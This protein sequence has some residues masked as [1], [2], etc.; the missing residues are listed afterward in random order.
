[1]D[2]D[3]DQRLHLT[4][5]EAQEWADRNDT[6]WPFHLLMDILPGFDQANGKDEKNLT[7]METCC[8]PVDQRLT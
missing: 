2:V 6:H 5:H 7:E 3:K 1:M 8:F 4:R